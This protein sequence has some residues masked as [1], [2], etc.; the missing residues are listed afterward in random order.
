MQAVQPRLAEPPLRWCAR[1]QDRG[2]QCGAYNPA[3]D[4]YKKHGAEVLLAELSETELVLN[5]CCAFWKCKIETRRCGTTVKARS[6][7]EDERAVEREVCYKF[8]CIDSGAPV[9]NPARTP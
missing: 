5:L 1:A 9:N 3:A 2:Q 7:N 8:L 6:R 4:L